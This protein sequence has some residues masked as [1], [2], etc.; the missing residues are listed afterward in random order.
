MNNRVLVNA[1]L[2]VLAFFLGMV[3]QGY[4]DKTPSVPITHQSKPTEM[5]MYR[6]D[7]DLVLWYPSDAVRI[8]QKSLKVEGFPEL[9][10]DGK[11]GTQTEN[12]IVEWQKRGNQ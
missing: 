2:V 8:L 10:A 1:T 12:A 5:E 11:F 9:E 7:N 3:Y 6:L 4:L